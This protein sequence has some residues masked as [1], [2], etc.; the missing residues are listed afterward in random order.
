MKIRLRHF[1]WLVLLCVGFAQAAVEW[2]VRIRGMTTFTENAL[3]AELGIPEE[4]GVLDEQ[5]RDFL[6]KIARNSLENYYYS[7]GFFSSKISLQSTSRPDSSWL[8]VFDVFE[9]EKYRFRNTSIIMIEDGIQLMESSTM[10]TAKQEPFQF[11]HI[12]DDLLEVRNLYRMNGYLHVRVDHEERVD[13]NERIVDVIYQIDPGH[14][15]RM[16]SLH[17]LITR[18]SQRGLPK[19][20]LTDT[21]WFANLWESKPGQ[22]IDGTYLND[23]RTKLLS[24]QVFTQLQILDSLRQD[25]SGMSDIS[26]KGQ[27]RIPGETR[28]GASFEQTYGFGFSAE[29]KHRNLFG[30]FHE[31]SLRTMVAQNRQETSIGYANPLFLGTSIRL[32]PT[33]IRLD[34]RLLFSQEKLDPPKAF[35]DSLTQRYDVASQVDLSFGITSRIRSRSSA[36]LRYIKKPMS[37]QFRIKMETGLSFNYTDDIFEPTQ[38]MRVSPTVGVG[39]AVHSYSGITPSLGA[40]YPY[41]EVQNALYLP[42]YGPLYAALAYDYGRFLSEASEED[43]RSFFQGGSRSV[44]GYPF[45]SIY[46]SRTLAP[47]PPDT[48]PSIL[49]GL[50]PRYHHFSGELRLNLPTKALKAFQLVSFLDLARVIDGGTGYHRGQEMGIGGGLRYRWQVLTLRLDYTLKKNFERMELEPFNSSRITF[51]L[52]Q[53]I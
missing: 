53:A 7:E 33:A 36:E 17:T 12:S 48:A 8:Y 16:G 51:D 49:I 24:T 34:G 21:T 42:I 26:I 22:T 50:T 9:G 11:S 41:F 15:V 20:G 35:P 52:S 14:Q 46:P 37:Q 3:M 29:T 23:F 39:R 13:S 19:L 31:G 5:R 32:I 43:A 40:P 30:T 28:L 45:Q 18:S 27:E 25:Q 38:G 4:F 47:V 2:E 6:M 44:R 10:R 1:L